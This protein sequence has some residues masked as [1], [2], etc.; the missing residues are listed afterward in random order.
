MKLNNRMFVIIGLTVLLCMGVVSNAMA[1]FGLAVM[2]RNNVSISGEAASYTKS[3]A[4]GGSKMKLQ[5]QWRFFLKD[6]SGNTTYQ[7]N[8]SP[9]SSQVLLSEAQNANIGAAIFRWAGLDA[10]QK[11]RV[12]AHCYLDTWELVGAS[13]HPYREG[14]WIHHPEYR[15]QWGYY[16]VDMSKPVKNISLKSSYTGFYNGTN[17]NDGSGPKGAIHP[18]MLLVMMLGTGGV[19]SMRKRLIGGTM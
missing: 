1:G 16:E 5:Y 11:Y 14:T 2:P 8:N 7:T 13:T 6:G 12:E 17:A 10:T 9:W 15:D 18:L 4:N 19:I 3:Y